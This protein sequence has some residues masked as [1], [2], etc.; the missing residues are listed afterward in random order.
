MT[1]SMKKTM[2]TIFVVAPPPLTFQEIKLVLHAELSEARHHLTETDHF[3]DP[4]SPGV[5]VGLAER[6]S[7]IHVQACFTGSRSKRY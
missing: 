2:I 4:A 3:T 6:K 5:E 7:V 1:A